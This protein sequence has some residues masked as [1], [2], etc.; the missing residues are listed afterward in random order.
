MTVSRRRQRYRESLR[1]EIL[2]AARALFVE[3]GY[4]A[5]SIRRIAERIGASSGILYHYFEDKPAIMAQLVAEAF[6]KLSQRMG[7][8]ARDAAPPLD[9]LR[10]AALTYIHFALENPHHYAVLFLKNEA[11]MAE[12]VIRDVFLR[13]GMQS[14]G[15]L[16]RITRACIEAGVLR[17][18]LTDEN[19]VAQSLWAGVHG[20]AALLITCSA[21]P[22]VEQTRLVD[23]HVDILIAG[24]KRT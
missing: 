2:D 17:P 4:E 16:L 20:I 22:F 24:V 6:A 5:T 13:D 8:I 11:S 14:F 7:S 3:S 12:P 21:F 9:S 23:R 1:Q 15:C 19:E 10:R 18:E